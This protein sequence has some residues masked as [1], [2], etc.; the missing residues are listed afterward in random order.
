MKVTLLVALTGLTGATTVA[1]QSPIRPGRWETVMQMEMPNLPVKMPEMKSTRCIT[2]EQAK[3]PAT[4][5]P[6]RTAGRS[7]W[8]E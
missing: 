5:S 4:R 8:S 6:T 1:A 2:P 7:R 3:D